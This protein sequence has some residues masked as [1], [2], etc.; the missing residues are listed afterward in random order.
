M[1]A[2]IKQAVASLGHKVLNVFRPVARVA[3]RARF[4]IAGAVALVLTG[5]RAMADDTVAL[6]DPTTVITTANT[7]LVSV[8]TL[9]AG[10]VGFFL[11]VKIVK[12]IRK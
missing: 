1:F 7:T 3:S 4:A 5:Y 8:C 2:E 10:A 11:V 12:W 9:V 6:P